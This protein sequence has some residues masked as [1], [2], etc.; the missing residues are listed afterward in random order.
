[1]TY[2]SGHLSAGFMQPGPV[3]WMADLLTSRLTDWL[4]DWLADRLLDCLIVSCMPGLLGS[5]VY[6]TTG[7]QLSKLKVDYSKTIL[8]RFPCPCQYAP[9]ILPMTKVLSANRK[10]MIKWM[11]DRQAKANMELCFSS[12]VFLLS[13]SCYPTAPSRASDS[14]EWK[15]LEGRKRE[16]EEVLRMY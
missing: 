14:S 4:T 16:T 12:P 3:D 11:I 10:T 15:F 13:G 6:F 7:T 9:L 1:M 8:L 2:L 5:F